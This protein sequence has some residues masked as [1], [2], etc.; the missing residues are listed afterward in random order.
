MVTFCRYYL[1]DFLIG[2]ALTASKQSYIWYSI[3]GL[4]NACQSAILLFVIS[5]TN[6]QDDAGVYSIGYA[7]ACLAITVG[8]FGMRNYQATDLNHKHSFK[9]YLTSRIITDI[10][11]MLVVLFY[12]IRG[13]VFLNYSL[14]KC[15]VILFLGLLKVVDSFE[16]VW[17]G[18]YQ[19]RGRLDVAGKCMTSRYVLMIGA[20]VIVL[21]VCNNLVWASAISFIVSLL[22]FIYTTIL[23]YPEIK[24]DFW[25]N[26][27]LGDNSL[28]NNKEISELLKECFP[29]FAG[30]FLAIYMANAPKYAIDELRPSTEQALFNYIFMPV[31]VVNVLNTFIYQPMLTTMASSYEIKDFKK[32]IK[33]FFRQIG[34]IFFL[35]LAVLIGGYLLGI[36]VLSIFYNTDLTELKMPFMFLLIG[37]GFLG[38]EGYL[39]AIITVMRKQK[40]LLIGF[41][42]S[43]VLALLLSR[44]AV[45]K[46]G[47]MGASLLYS[48]IIML[49]M[50]VF[51][52]IFL[53]IWKRKESI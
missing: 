21:V 12:I 23:V 48:G 38:M 37:S 50:L 45:I 19:N 33:L 29:L 10:A 44:P 41:G 51:I 32:F 1:K 4:L 8:S 35:V 27:N 7:I 3:G 39:Q 36:P 47:I 20:M 40:F 13:T 25:E 17:H 30:C 16:D 31:Y 22:Y 18:F 34:I 42:I 9:T 52:I 5:R 6:S 43:A 2:D 46:W 28:I 14:D 26:R 49:Q 24:N 53:I 11:M 15:L